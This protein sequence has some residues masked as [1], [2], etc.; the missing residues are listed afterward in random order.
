MGVGVQRHVLA[1]LP[2]GMTRYPLN[3]RLG[4]PQGQS[5]RVQKI[6]PPP[7]FAF[8]TVQSIASRYTDYATLAHILV[9]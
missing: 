5:V 9:V 3:D 7:G 2:P 8:W 6:S 4:G 1:A